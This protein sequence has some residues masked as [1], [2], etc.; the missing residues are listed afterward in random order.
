LCGAC[1]I[2]A[3]SCPASNPFRSSREELKT[4]IDMPQLP[5]DRMRQ[6]VREAVDKMTG[7]LKIIVFGCEHGI[8]VE[9]LNSG[10]TLGIKLI[11]SGMLP[12]TLVEYALKEGADGVMVTGCRQNDCYFRFGNS[13]TRLRF[14]GER[15]PSLRARAE[16]DRILIHGAAE[17]DAPAIERDL[18]AFRQ[19]LRDRNRVAVSAVGAEN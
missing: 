9:R 12:P 7:D 4:G 6:Q 15:K 10:D 11:C 2:C 13:W 5:V 19:H 18:V 1:G 16:R 17:P 14:A 8:D 3:G